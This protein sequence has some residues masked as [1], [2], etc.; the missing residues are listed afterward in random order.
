MEETRRKRVVEETSAKRIEE[1]ASDWVSEQ[2]YAAWRDKLQYR[3]FI[4]ERGFSKWISLFQEIV[5]SKG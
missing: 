5:E 3:D 4:W 1:K 2:A